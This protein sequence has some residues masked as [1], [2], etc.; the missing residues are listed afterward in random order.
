MNKLTS[1]QNLAR[2]IIFILAA[3]F[4]ISP[5][6]NP[7]IGLLLGIILSQTIGNPFYQYNQKATKI[8][9]QVSIVGLGFGMN[10]FEAMK[11]SKEGFWFTMISICFTLLIGILIGRI[12]KI[13][14]KTSF[15]ISVGTAICGGSA[16]A[17][18]SPIIEAE[19]EQISISL[20]IVFIL[21][22]IALFIFPAIG[23]YFQFSQ[24]QF[25]LWAAI[26]IHDTSSVVG[27]AQKY[28]V[29]ALQIATTIKLERALWIIPISLITAL[30]VKGKSNKI[31]IPYFIFFFI[32]AMIFNTFLPQLKD[33]NTF[34]VFLAK[35]GLTLTLFLIGAG[36]TRDTLKKIGIKPFIAGIILWI[37]VL[38]ISFLVILNR[39]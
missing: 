38:T 35:R 7:P 15:L 33:I 18:V 23:H 24:S 6:G 3:L 22:A 5:F 14:K 2:K 36:L 1:E 30:L 4:C 29:I 26:A 21:N 19:K 28:G 31:K 17:A 10:L 25:G 20:G 37:L 16:I 8:L 12:L 27:A 11:A 13:N 39:K 32:A 9:L 34:I